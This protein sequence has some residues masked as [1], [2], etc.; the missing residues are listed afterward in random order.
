[1]SMLGLNNG[2]AGLIYSLFEIRLAMTVASNTIWSKC[3]ASEM[4]VFAFRGH[5]GDAQEDN[6]NVCMGRP[7]LHKK[8]CAR[9]GVQ[10]AQGK[11][12]AGVLSRPSKS[13]KF[14]VHWVETLR[15]VYIMR[16]AQPNPALKSGPQNACMHDSRRFLMPSS[17]F[18]WARIGAQ[19]T[20][21]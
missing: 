5:L 6:D 7:L 12:I 9:D 18:W 17:F 8:V 4:E 20:F 21:L 3:S 14:E 16:P 10:L 15:T 11:T 19:A 13:L 1:M 2:Y